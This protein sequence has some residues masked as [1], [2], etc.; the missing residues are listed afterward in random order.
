[1][2]PATIQYPPD[3]SSE[4]FSRIEQQS[5]YQQQSPLGRTVNSHEAHTYRPTQHILTK[6]IETM[7]FASMAT[8]E[9]HITPVGIVLAE[10]LS[11]FQDEHYSWDL[12]RFASN[13][14]FEVDQIAKLASACGSLDSLLVVLPQEER[15]V[16]AGIATPHSRQILDLDYL[17]RVLI[18]KPGVI[19]VLRG[20]WEVVRYERGNIPP[21]PPT[22]SK[23]DGQ[24]R[25]QLNAIER[26]VFQEDPNRLSIDVLNFLLRIVKRMRSLGHGG[27]LAVLGPGDI[28]SMSLKD[29]RQLAEP[30][31]FGTAL[32]EMYG[33]Q[34]IDEQ[35]TTR[36]FSV[37]TLNFR[38]PSDEEEAAAAAAQEATQRVARMIDQ[39]ARFTTVDG[40]VVMSHSLDVLAFGAKLSSK[41]ETPAVY[42]VTHDRCSGERWPIDR[43]G[44]RHRAAAIFAD[45]YSMGL[46]LIVSQDGEAAIFQQLESKVV[47]WPVSV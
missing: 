1:M 46:A 41:E 28:Q 29:A 9:G 12:V 14:S 11:P 5:S 43:R 13:L 25:T 8:E 39:I 26:T 44:T 6:A 21:S 20:E 34:L 22:L 33:A 31:R 7:L 3:V 15:L 2:K 18:L 47:H 37:K 40:A 45:R 38:P 16:V 24:H 17:V 35:N 23:G 30:L 42:S 10:S 32:L 36:R 27:L 4:F 19:S